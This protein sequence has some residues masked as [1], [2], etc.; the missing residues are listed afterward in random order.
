[1]LHI[2]EN[3]QRQLWPVMAALARRGFAVPPDEAHDL[4]QDFYS[5]EW[6]RFS[7]NY[8]PARGSFERYQTNRLA[9]FRTRAD[10][11]RATA[12]VSLHVPPDA[13]AVFVNARS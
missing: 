7:E 3:Y 6:Q 13:D 4:I 10:K 8:D 1:M 12:N 2:F 5:D 11:T 9:L